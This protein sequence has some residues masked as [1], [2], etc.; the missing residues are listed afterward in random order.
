LATL[1]P[2][3]DNEIENVDPEEDAIEET[4]VMPATRQKEH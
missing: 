1:Y 2:D 3:E 4:Y